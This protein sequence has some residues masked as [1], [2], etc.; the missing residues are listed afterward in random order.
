MEIR[1]TAK[2]PLKISLPAG[3]RLFLGIGGTGQITP[4]A[5]EHPPVKKLLE[6]GDIEITDA[7]HAGAVKSTGND[8]SI[9]TSSAQ[10]G[11][12]ASRQSGDR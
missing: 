3:K 5:A 7:G 12:R 8:S 1:N 2:R 11:G 10:G 4:K 6:A 9:P